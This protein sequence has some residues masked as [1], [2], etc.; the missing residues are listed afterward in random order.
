MRCR[1]RDAQIAT[2]LA[3]VRAERHERAAA[4]A[5]GHQHHHD[6]AV[7]ALREKFRVPGEGDP[8]IVDHALLHR[9]GDECGELARDAAIGRAC[10]RLEHVGCVARVERAGVR[11][12]AQRHVQAAQAGARALRACAAVVVFES[13]IDIAMP[14]SRAQQMR[15]GYHDE[16]GRKIGRGERRD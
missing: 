2:A 13:E 3:V 14:R 16:V 8:G 10:E 6:V 1:Q 9:R 15:I 4:R 5:R 12:R 7:R 11:W